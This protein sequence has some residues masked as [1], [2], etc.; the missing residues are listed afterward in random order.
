MHGGL[1][2]S[3]RG[4]ETLLGKRGKRVGVRSYEL[5]RQ[6]GP[7]GERALSVE[8]GRSMRDQIQKRVADPEEV[9]RT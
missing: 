8:R 6:D 5:S 3:L 7:Y 4:S 1:L 2:I 9:T